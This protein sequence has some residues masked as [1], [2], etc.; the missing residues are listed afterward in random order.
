MRGRAGAGLR[1]G[2]RLKAGLRL[3]L[4]LGLRFGAG[5]RA[6]L[7]IV[8]VFGVLCVIPTRA[9]AEVRL[10]DIEFIPPV[11][12]VGD[13]VE[14][15]ITLEADNPAA[16]TVPEVLP[17]AEWVEIR[18]VHVEYGADRVTV[19]AVFTP[20]AAG[21]R[22]LP[23]LSLGALQ[24]NAIKVPTQSVLPAAHEGARRPRGQLVL[25]G[26]RMALALILG[27]LAS[28][29]FGVY[30]GSR[31]VWGCFV[32][33]RDVFL[34][35]R[36]ARRL[37]KVMKRLKAG[38]ASESAAA[39]FSQLTDGLRSY[40]SERTGRDCRS[41]TTAEIGKM[42]EFSSSECPAG[43]LLAVLHNG[44]MVKFAGQLA[45]EGSLERTLIEVESAVA[46]WEKSHAEL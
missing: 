25:P 1:F 17:N 4:R 30:A 46:E 10:E 5:L 6:G 40:L 7:G 36:P 34:I 43:R 39:W 11:F 29:P 18:D 14:L 44:D 42:H 37:Q 26:T 28:A 21:T 19:T 32:R 33:F 23:N 41:S 38:A 45:D 27:F 3:G 24:L 2:A 8:C 20:F 9:G 16:V 22:T 31:F 12:F 35:H 15:R 13:S